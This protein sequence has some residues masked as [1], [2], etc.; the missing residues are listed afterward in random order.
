M[1]FGLCSGFTLAGDMKLLERVLVTAVEGGKKLAKM[2]PRATA[3]LYDLMNRQ[4]F[5]DL[6]WHERMLADRVRIE[7]YRKGISGSVKPG[8][9]VI[10][11][12]TGTAAR[13]PFSD[14]ASA[15]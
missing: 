1:D 11:L 4:V 8:D 12:G 5:T 15:A 6:L 14:R 3:Y 2:S 10:D 9:V 13:S 7:A